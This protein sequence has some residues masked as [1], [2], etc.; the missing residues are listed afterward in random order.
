MLEK[1][2]WESQR[3]RQRDVGLRYTLGLSTSV[4]SFYI[5]S[6]SLAP[7][8]LAKSCFRTPLISL[9]EDRDEGRFG[10]FRNS[11]LIKENGIFSILTCQV[12]VVKYPEA[13]SG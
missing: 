2:G 9:G 5:S 10:K 6:Q 8:R 12:S 3:I 11:R 13:I 1:K 7:F 4:A